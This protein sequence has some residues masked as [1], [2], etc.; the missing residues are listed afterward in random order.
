MKSKLL[1][2]GAAVGLIFYAVVWSWFQSQQLQTAPL[3][4]MLPLNAAGYGNASDITVITPEGKPVSLSSMK[5]KVVLVDFWGTWCGPCMQSMPGLAAVY[6]KYHDKGYETIGVA[7]E[8][9]SGS[10]IRP[11]TEK[12]GVNYTVGMA[13]KRSEL[14]AYQPNSLPM[15]YIIDKKGVIRYKQ[16]G[17]DP[18]VGET[19]ISVTVKKLLDEN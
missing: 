11:V 18:Q 15:M 16:T 1:I 4:G 8:Q 5:G 12:L 10:K 13:T 6:N 19:D 17:F 9:D 2:V 3:D 7:L 14:D